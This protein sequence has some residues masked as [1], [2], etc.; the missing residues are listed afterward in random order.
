MK[1]GILTHY[2][3][4]DNYG[5]VLQCYALQQFLKSIGHDPY[6]IVYQPTH[7]K[8]ILTYFRKLALS[9][10]S[11]ISNNKSNWKKQLDHYEKL[12]II[13]HKKNKER[14]FKSFI[15]S[16]ISIS[17][18]TYKSPND[19]LHRYPTA[20]AYIVGSDQVWN[21]PLKSKES[22]IWYLNFG[23]KSTLRISYAASFGRIIPDYEK[24]E[25]FQNLQRFNGISFRET[26]GVRIGQSLGFKD[27]I[28][29][30]DPTL[31]IDNKIYDKL[32]NQ[33]D[34]P[35]NQEYV[36][37]Y[38]LNIS[39]PEEIKWTELDRFL[40]TTNLKLISVNAS[41]YY[42][43]DDIIPNV[44][45]H[46]LTIPQWISHINYSKIVISTSFHGIVFAIIFHKPFIAILLENQYNEGND[47]I[48]SLLKNLGLEDRI[49]KNN[50]ESIYSK[51][52][53]WE[54]VD[55]KLNYLKNQSRE[56]IIKNLTT[57]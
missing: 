13:N 14:N 52:I 4:E 8:S 3:T 31:I 23:D 56:F 24:K 39:K 33:I 40:H 57:K 20:D 12:R 47:R 32:I 16:N 41:G 17:E 2:G 15:E 43:A 11:L 35:S 30:L 19:L 7:K 55:L 46:C 22:Q 28:Q 44:V 18:S 9:I 51:H 38:Y 25:L 26:S 37:L 21:V 5:Q 27:S 36:F 54:S 29:V 34:I 10:F 42:P 1:I 6:L 48:I 45:N 49:L 50:F 53:D